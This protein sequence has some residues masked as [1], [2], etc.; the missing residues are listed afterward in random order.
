[1]MQYSV[2]SYCWPTLGADLNVG[3]A[4]NWRMLSFRLDYLVMTDGQ[5]RML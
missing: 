5:V 3:Q 2:E 1:M 4:F